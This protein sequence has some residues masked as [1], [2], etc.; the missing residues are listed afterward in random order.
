[1][2]VTAEEEELLLRWLMIGECSLAPQNR[3]SS[4]SGPGWTLRSL[5]TGPC[6]VTTHHLCSL[7][8]PPSPNSFGYTFT[9]RSGKEAASPLPT[10]HR[11]HRPHQLC[12]CLSGAAV[13]KVT[14]KER[15]EEWKRG[16]E[17]PSSEVFR[18]VCA[19]TGEVCWDLSSSDAQ[20]VVHSTAVVLLLSLSMAPKRLWAESAGEDR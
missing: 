7:A 19:R 20:R 18:D 5:S 15:E 14:F 12:V 17:F 16:R 1:M 4:F 6:C 2:C 10:D 8:V 13:S 9:Y 3:R 11:L